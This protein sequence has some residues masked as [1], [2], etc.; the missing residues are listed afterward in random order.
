MS[1]DNGAQ[2]IL[3]TERPDGHFDCVGFTGLHIT[4]PAVIAFSCDDTINAHSDLT[5][6]KSALLARL[7]LL[8]PK[9]QSVA[10]NC[11]GSIP[12][13]GVCHAQGQL[14]CHKLLVLIGDRTQPLAVK[15]SHQAW[16]VGS[17]VH[18]V[19]PV[20]PI[21]ARSGVSGLLPPE[22]R[23]PNVNFW[24]RS[25][26]EVLPSI[27]AIAGLTV[28]NPRIFISYR[29][30][31]SAAFAIQLFDALSHAGFDVFLD[32]FRISPGV[33]FQSRLTQE[34][35]DKS[36]MLLIES[37]HI[38]ESEWTMYEINTAKTCSLGIF[39]L[40][41]PGGK[42]APGIDSEVR[43]ELSSADFIG[44]TYSDTAKLEQ[45]VLDTLVQRVRAE[46]DRAIVAR[47]RILFDS[48]DGALDLEGVTL[49][50]I[51]TSGVSIARARNNTE[52]VLWLTPRP[53][54]LLDFH[55]VY[56][57]AASPMRGVV[58][59]LSRLMEPARLEQTNWLASIAQL[60]I[61]DEGMIKTAAAEIAQG[62]L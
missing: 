15:P 16:I 56:G 57:H 13:A 41:V 25:I 10:M 5:A 4:Y 37:E 19:L 60:K 58:I 12:D 59:G 40:Y 14:D 52:Y 44:G 31:D 1:L 43:Q 9:L 33:N 6:L 42:M 35:G 11:R 36:M 32:H 2:L 24:T 48:L 21:A 38:L 17:P 46:H 30:K 29:Q 28:E 34:L 27:L 39:G 62:T 50:P 3:Q 8:N 51:G 47:R 20:F 54:E 49:E 7:H 55:G 18:R 53:P 26:D 22:F 61:V 45:S 23:L